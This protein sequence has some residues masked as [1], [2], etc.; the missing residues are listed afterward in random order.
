[1]LSCL[2]IALLAVQ[3]A[4]EEL[5]QVLVHGDLAHVLVVALLDRLLLGAQVLGLLLLHAHACLIRLGGAGRPR[6]L[7]LGSAG[8]HVDNGAQGVQV[9]IPC[10]LL[11]DVLLVGSHLLVELAHFRVEAHRRVLVHR[12][13]LQ[14]L[15]LKFLVF[16]A[17]SA[18]LL[19][20]RG[21]PVL[22]RLDLFVYLVHHLGD[23]FERLP[24]RL[25]RG[26]LALRH[27]LQAKLGLRIPADAL[28]LLH[29]LQLGP[30]RPCL[31]LQEL[32]RAVEHAKLGAELAQGGLELLV[33][34]CLAPERGGVLFEVLR[35]GGHGARPRLGAQ[36]LELR[37][38]G[39]QL[40]LEVLALRGG[41][42]EALLHLV[43]L[44]RDERRLLPEHAQA[45]VCVG[46]RALRPA[47]LVLQLPQLG[48]QA[49]HV[50]ARLA[51]LLLGDGALVDRALELREARA[52]RVEHARQL[53]VAE[54]AVLVH[55]LLQLAQELLATPREVLG[56]RLA[57]HLRHVRH[58][59]LRVRQLRPLLAQ[60]ALEAHLLVL[61]LAQGGDGV[62]H[63]LVVVHS[64]QPA[65]ERVNFV[66][67]LLLVLLHLHY[68]ALDLRGRDDLLLQLVQLLVRILELLLQRA[69]VL[70]ELGD[71]L[72]GVHV[73]RQ[74]VGQ[75][76]AGEVGALL[77]VGQAHQHPVEHGMDGVRV[78]LQQRLLKN[79]GIHS[80]L[81][82]EL[83]Q[84]L[85]HAI[86]GAL[87]RLV[88]QVHLVHLREVPH[89]QVDNLEELKG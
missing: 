6:G 20:L 75:Q 2:G 42:V 74:V 18:E 7:R 43:A 76:K 57:H 80:W 84:E 53:L 33:L 87:W 55:L 78:S 26:R 9:V 72:V 77:E 65:P 16:G 70:V 47:L 85:H 73:L 19:D 50:R 71:L 59:V 28:G 86:D 11:G 62:E 14:V 27:L 31:R 54:V 35:L 5:V 3:L 30:H 82:V 4:L 68:G 29:L 64:L 60:A 44:A 66:D 58:L 52:L 63:L 12:P 21:Q 34:R 37:H 36:R 22:A 83:A 23:L 1:M 32:L 45:V 10:L 25:V 89:D 39:H 79:L 48:L 67:E 8:G 17:E 51:Q 56:L 81:E 88:T 49:R 40:A 38:L 41:R 46:V 24:L 61:L 13:L 15:A 69:Q